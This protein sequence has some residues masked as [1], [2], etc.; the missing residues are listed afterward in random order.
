MNLFS[1]WCILII[2][3]GSWTGTNESIFIVNYVFVLLIQSDQSIMNQNQSEKDEEKNS[4][5]SID[6]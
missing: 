6:S 2:Y 4:K 1:I 3:L 5:V